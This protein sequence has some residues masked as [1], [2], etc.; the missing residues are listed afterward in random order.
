[1]SDYPAPTYTLKFSFW[2]Y[3]Q[4]VKTITAT[5]S[6]SDHDIAAAVS[7][8]TPFAAGEWQWTA[9]VEKGADAT[10]ERYTVESGTVTIKPRLAAAGSTSDLRSHAQKMLDAIEAAMFGRATHAELSLTINGKAIQYLKPNELR[11]ERAYFR[12]E[13]AEEKR[14]EDI[15]QGKSSSRR[16][17]TEF[18]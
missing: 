5:A 9:Y 1:M 18:R 10:L 7:V 8:T 3:G 14:K 2:L 4:A 13:V 12:N 6:G 17:V 16:I 11:E 15:A